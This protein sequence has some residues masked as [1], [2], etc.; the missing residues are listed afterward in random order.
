MSLD[1]RACFGYTQLLNSLTKISCTWTEDTATDPKDVR[2]RLGIGIPH[3]LDQIESNLKIPE[4]PNKRV[5]VDDLIDANLPHIVER[6]RDLAGQLLFACIGW[7]TMLYSATSQPHS[8]LTR[9]M[10]MACRSP[11][12]PETL[13]SVTHSQGSRTELRSILKSLDIWPL[14]EALDS[15]DVDAEIYPLS[16]GAP[17]EKHLVLKPSI[18]KD[19][20]LFTECG[21]KISLSMHLSDHLRLI[22]TS[23]PPQLLL[24]AYPSFCLKQLT[25]GDSSTLYKVLDLLSD[26]KPR[27]NTLLYLHEMLRSY[28]LL[29]GRSKPGP[30]W[31]PRGFSYA[32]GKVHKGFIPFEPF[33]HDG[34][35]DSDLVDLCTRDVL[36]AHLQHLDSDKERWDFNYLY[37]RLVKVQEVAA[38]S[39]GRN[40]IHVGGPGGWLVFYQGAVLVLMSLLPAHVS[41]T[42]S[43][44]T[45]RSWYKVMLEAL[46]ET[47]R[48]VSKRQM[49]KEIVQRIT[50]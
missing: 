31:A 49:V 9:Y 32:W 45:V 20:K 8:S 23:R 10:I 26:D 27:F 11:P 21:L 4:R 12:C 28:R 39:E 43:L 35:F 30:G 15:L 14:I 42:R 50:V 33:A 38:D 36:P 2:A 1:R 19:Q 46:P 48:A 25:S 16:D 5:T 22:D 24:F 34:E 41:T 7:A 37:D 29:F 3:L 44:H 18:F 17:L 40:P 13:L 6:D 47:Y